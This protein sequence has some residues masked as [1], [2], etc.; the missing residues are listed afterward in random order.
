LSRIQVFVCQDVYEV[1][2]ILETLKKT[3][4]VSTSDSPTVSRLVVIDS[5]A[6][7]MNGVLRLSDGVG[8]KRLSWLA[9]SLTL[10]G[11][12]VSNEFFFSVLGHATM[13]HTMRV[14]RGMAQK[15]AL[16]VLV[17]N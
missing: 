6:R 9:R 8:T 17:S 7:T 12:A 16:A 4:E 10:E 13:M 5:L 15:H 3:L 11:P 2:D 1:L 14:L